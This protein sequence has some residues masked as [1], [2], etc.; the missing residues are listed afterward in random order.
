VEVIFVKDLLYAVLGLISA[1]LA[2]FFM[3]SYIGQKAA[4]ASS[5]SFI[6]AIVFAVLA[7][8]FGVL[9][10]SGRVNKQEEI[11]ITE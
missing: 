1:A 10:M 2:A 9:F 4:E 3:Y 11:H 8:V 5:T 6:I 7:L